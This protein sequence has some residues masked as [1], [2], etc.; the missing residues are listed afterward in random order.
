VVRITGS[1]RPPPADL[2]G[3]TKSPRPFVLLARRKYR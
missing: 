3:D 2:R 1:T